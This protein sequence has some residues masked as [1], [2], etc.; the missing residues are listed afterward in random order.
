MS[1]TEVFKAD[2]LPL[3]T[4]RNV[5]KV[6]E[7][8][9]VLQIKSLDILQGEILALVGPSG[10]GKSTLL[11]LLNFLEPPS[12]GE[13]TFAGFR[14]NGAGIALEQQ[15]RVTT[16]FQRSIL[17]SRSVKDNVA[18]GLRIRGKRQVADAVMAVLAQVGLEHLAN[19]PAQSLSGGEIQRVALARALV[20]RP[21][22]LLLDEP[23]ANLDPNNVRL[24]ED[25]IQKANQTQG[26]TIV[27]V[28]HN[29]FQ[30]RR[31]AKRIA[32]MLVGEIVEVGPSLM[33][34]NSPTDPRTTAFMH[35]D[36]IY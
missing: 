11:R 29:I 34:F 17:L 32:L 10:A 28:T 4:L 3:Y 22:V 23:T 7:Q 1:A 13:I 33:M 6:Y 18:Y 31:L 9:S 27:L 26:V 25:I 36:M 24:I 30:A 14:L 12:A 2:N 19:S 20:V 5:S 21:D 8:R 16:V 35:G 15:R